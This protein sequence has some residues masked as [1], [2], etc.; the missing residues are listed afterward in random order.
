MGITHGDV[1]RFSGD[2][3]GTAV[4]HAF[5]LASRLDD[6]RVVMTADVYDRG[7]A[8]DVGLF[9]PVEG[10]IEEWPDCSLRLYGM[11]RPEPLD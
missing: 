7:A 9:A 10:P 6:Y 3:Y 8:D 5:L 1:H 4:N 11:L 2:L